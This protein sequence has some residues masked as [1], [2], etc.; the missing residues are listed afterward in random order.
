M[1]L[2][3]LLSQEHIVVALDIL[4]Q[5]VDA[6]NNMRSPI[7]DIEISKFISDNE[8]KLTFN[9]NKIHSSSWVYREYV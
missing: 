1:S 7:E 8:L 4:Q 3:V 6:V 9:S 5:S 2:A